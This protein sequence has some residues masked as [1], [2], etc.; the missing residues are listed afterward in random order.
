LAKLP[1]QPNL[2][3]L[4]K[5]A[6]RRL[7]VLRQSG[8]P[9]QLAHAQFDLAKDFG[10][11][12]WRDLKANVDALTVQGQLIA[13]A[14]NGEAATLA[15]LLDA[16]PDL[17]DLRT[18]PYEMTLLHVG[19]RHAGIVDLLLRRG[20]DPNARER[21]D[22]TYA[23]HWAAA[24][25]ALDSVRRLADA[26]GDVVGRGDDHQM[27][28]IGWASCWDGCQ[29]DAH[30]AVREFLISR[31]A[32]HHIFSAM[33]CGELDEVRRLVAADPAVLTSRQ[34]RNENNRTPLQYAVVLN[35]PE[36][37][38]L[39]LELG[40]DPLAVDGWGLPVAAYAATPEIDR[41]VMER[42]HA[43]TAS[44]IV[45]ADRGDRTMNAGAMDLMASVALDDWPAAERLV[46]EQP[47]LVEL[48]NGV[49]HL[50]AKRGDADAVAWLLRH[51]A[52][53]NAT[54]A[55]WDSEVTPMHLAI[56]TNQPAV[57]RALLDAGADPS[58]KDTK[59]TSDALGWAE[60][61]DR[62]EVVEMLK[63]H[64]G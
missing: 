60:F 11:T 20:F 56:M 9:A 58:I 43:L 16:H 25:G 2:E 4:R 49:L 15:A 61:F 3:W 52:N 54:Y 37:V 47:R 55:H 18:Q 48:S 23:M 27:D 39:L 26:G 57:V 6:K 17:I 24:A 38:S 13:A 7:R 42:I 41:P 21:G 40:A 62:K 29:D 10:F 19:A 59:H 45:S 5:Q 53:P 63:A 51:G 35:K 14:K 1:E 50:M 36:L 30:R 32:T 46:R 33:A 44:E 8:L 64:A 22:N 28:V 12:S 34:S 31:G